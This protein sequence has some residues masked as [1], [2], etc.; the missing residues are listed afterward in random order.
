MILF[1]LVTALLRRLNQLKT[2]IEIMEML[3]ESVAWIVLGFVPTLF[4][5]EMSWRMGKMIG[6]R[7]MT[8]GRILQQQKTTTIG[9]RK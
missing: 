9:G 2:D 1:D 4:C 6:K 8:T 3:L 5:L 7:R